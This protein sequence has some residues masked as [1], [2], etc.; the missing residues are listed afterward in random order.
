MV[1]RAQ[2]L[3]GHLHRGSRGIR[4]SDPGCLLM[5]GTQ[6]M[7]TE[8]PRTPGHNLSLFLCAISGLILSSCGRAASVEIHGL[9]VELDLRTGRNCRDPGWCLGRTPTTRSVAWDGAA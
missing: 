7:E 1:W 5:A 8:H 2:V 4:A 9:E 6:A 3:P